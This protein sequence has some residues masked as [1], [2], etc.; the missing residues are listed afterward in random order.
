MS[1]P[2]RGQQQTGPDPDR[3]SPSSPPL[4]LSLLSLHSR[5]GLPTPTTTA[6]VSRSSPRLLTCSPLSGRERR[7]RVWWDVARVCRCEPARVSA[8]TERV[9]VTPPLLPPPA[10]YTPA[11][12]GLTLSWTSEN[13]LCNFQH[14]PPVRPQSIQDRRGQ[15]SMVSWNVYTD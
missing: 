11:R 10:Q 3:Q 8:P 13:N 12:H 15:F 7:V 9:T 6:T 2:C 4:L 14:V 1:A 5:P